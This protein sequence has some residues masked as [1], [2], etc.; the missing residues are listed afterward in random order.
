MTQFVDEVDGVVFN[1]LFFL[2]W[3]IVGTGVGALEE[4]V[5]FVVSN[6]GNLVIGANKF[7]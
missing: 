3:R 6:L 4:L 7:F 5:D 1:A 2:A